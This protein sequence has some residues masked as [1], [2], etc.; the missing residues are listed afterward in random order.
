M[1]AVGLAI[2]IGVAAGCGGSDAPAREKSAAR[3]PANVD[4]RERSDAAARRLGKLFVRMHEVDKDMPHLTLDPGRPLAS[5]RADAAE[6]KAELPRYEP[7]KAEIRKEAGRCAAVADA[8]V[9]RAAVLLR[10]MITLRH[11]GTKRSLRMFE[12]RGLDGAVIAY[13]DRLGRAWVATNKEWTAV[14]ARINE[15]YSRDTF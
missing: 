3:P 6:L 14:V 13:A 12:S 11:D 9:R 5:I 7:I 4:A 15:R 8:D 2:A 10:M 1:A